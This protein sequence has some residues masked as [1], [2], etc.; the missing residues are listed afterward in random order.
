MKSRNFT[1]REFTLS[2]ILVAFL[3]VITLAVLNSRQSE[4]PA[5]AAVTTAPTHTVAAPAKQLTFEDGLVGGGEADAPVGYRLYSARLL[6][7]TFDKTKEYTFENDHV[8]YSYFSDL[9]SNRE[10]ET[11]N[12]VRDAKTHEVVRSNWS[13]YRSNG[14][15]ET[16]SGRVSS[17]EVGE[18]PCQQLKGDRFEHAKELIKGSA[19]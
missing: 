14:L 6:P 5:A 2:L 18:Q 10:Y 9:N 11:L 16:S 15:I 13:L 3:T 19:R 17:W 1:K 12:L 7:P 8:C 4:A